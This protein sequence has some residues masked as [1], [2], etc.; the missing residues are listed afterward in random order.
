MAQEVGL[1]LL[2][3]GVIAVAGVRVGE[4][5]R[6]R[7]SGAVV[8]LQWLVE[9]SRGEL[10]A[11][12]TVELLVRV[13]GGGRNLLAGRLGMVALLEIVAHVLD[14]RELAQRPV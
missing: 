7:A 13:A 11:H 14:G 3:D 5:L 4:Q 10:D 6:E 12:E 8:G 2:V 9:R 1:E